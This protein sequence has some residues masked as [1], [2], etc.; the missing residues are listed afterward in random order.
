MHNSHWGGV[1]ISFEERGMVLF[2]EL[3]LFLE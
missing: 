2:L 3:G 1:V